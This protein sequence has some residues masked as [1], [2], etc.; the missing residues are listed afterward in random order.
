MNQEDPSDPK[1]K[2]RVTCINEFSCDGGTGCVDKKTNEAA[3]IAQARFARP[4]DNINAVVAIQNRFKEL[5]EEGNG[6]GFAS[7]KVKVYDPSESGR[8]INDAT[9]FTSGEIAEAQ[10]TKKVLS[11]L[12]TRNLKSSRNVL[13]FKQ[14]LIL[15]RERSQYKVSPM[16]KEMIQLVRNSF[17]MKRKV[18]L[19]NWR[20][21]HSPLEVS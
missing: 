2:S 21:S 19:K 5:R 3:C 9:T 13:I 1:K 20:K 7:D 12:I 18:K 16:L 14:T 8:S 6:I 17:Q 11:Q 15:K 4:R 10:K